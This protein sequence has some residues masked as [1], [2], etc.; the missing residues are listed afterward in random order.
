MSP[1]WTTMGSSNA[2]GGRL[3]SQSKPLRPCQGCLEA[4]TLGSFPTLSSCGGAWR[5]PTSQLC[6]LRC[7]MRW[8]LSMFPDK[9]KNTDS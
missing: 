6:T 3:C 5:K 9:E 2:K 4:L 7:V 1:T 8:A